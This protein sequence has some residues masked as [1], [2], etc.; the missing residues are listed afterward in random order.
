[1]SERSQVLEQDAVRDA[2]PTYQ[3]KAPE[4]V[5]GDVP[6]GY[7]RTEVGVIPK[8]WNVCKIGELA[9]IRRGASPRPI[10]DPKWFDAKSDIG[11]LRISDVAREGKYVE[12]TDQ[13][14]S[15]LGVARSRLVKPGNLIMS[16]AATVGR[17]AVNRKIVCIHDGF[18]VFD[19]PTISL[20]FFYYLLLGIEN[21]W[22]EKGQ[23]GS[24]VNLNTHLISS[25]RIPLPGRS[26]EQR[27]IATALSDADALIESLDRLLDKKRAIKQAAMQ[28]LLTG[29]TRLLGFTGEWETKRLGDIAEIRGG[30]TPS[31]TA[32]TFWSGGIAWC[33][34]TDITAL[35]GRKY[36]SETA[37]TISETGLS[38]SSAEIIPRNSVIITS[39]ATIGECAINTTPMTTNQGFKNLVP[40]VCE[41][42]FLYYLMTTQKQR[43]TQLCAGSTFL[44]VGAKQL[45]I[46]EVNLPVDV[47]EQAAIA[48]VL[49]DMDTEIEALEHRRDKARQ[50]KQGMMQQLLTGRVRL[51]RVE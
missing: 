49:S 32:P 20:E 23:T 35:E 22:A 21:K 28:Q 19:K 39:R 13:N 8:D 38:T 31:T 40:K 50:I 6:P 36:L 34:P 10:A 45:K 16:M 29:Q 11:W 27:T 15:S 7:K 4:I 26:D 5:H 51:V 44:E 14:L 33:T 37:R 9:H 41:T 18:V 2:A 48:K 17:P 43:L 3:I 47:D 12:D 1:M 42:E 25:A 46:F 24:Q 30:G